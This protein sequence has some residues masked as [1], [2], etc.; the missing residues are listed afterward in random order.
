MHRENKE[1]SD[2]CRAVARGDSIAVTRFRR[3]VVPCLRTIVRRALRS[4][5][6]FSP[7]PKGIRAAVE[8]L[9]AKRASDSTRPDRPYPSHLARK[10]CDLL[11]EMVQSAP[12]LSP[13]ETVLRMFDPG[14]VRGGLS[15]AR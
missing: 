1:F 14:T 8:K 10:V 11:I 5:R 6:D 4:E 13:H 9:Q 2:L 7:V 12:G 3:T 15:S